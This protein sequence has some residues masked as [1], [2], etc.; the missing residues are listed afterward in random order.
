MI[1]LTVV[2]MSFSGVGSFDK[3]RF[4][5]IAGHLPIWLFQTETGGR[6]DVSRFHLIARCYTGFVS[7]LTV[8]PMFFTGVDSFDKTRF[9]FIA[10]H[11][12]KSL[13]ETE[14]VGRGDVLPFHLI[15][16]H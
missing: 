4:R 8:V 1:L 11:L 6:G 3:T 16:Q 15:A 13:P 9:R 12:P 2:S 14:T 7:L 5:F 10:G